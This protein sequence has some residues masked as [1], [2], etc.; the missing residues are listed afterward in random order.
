MLQKIRPYCMHS[1]YQLHAHLLNIGQGVITRLRK[2]HSLGR[3]ENTSIVIIA[4][5][6]L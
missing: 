6:P 3:D 2:A 5:P 4:E 1:K